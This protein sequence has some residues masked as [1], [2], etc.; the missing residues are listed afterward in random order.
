MEGNEDSKKR[1]A[2]GQLAAEITGALQ[3]HGRT[4]EENWLWRQLGDGHCSYGMCRHRHNRGLPLC[5]HSLTKLE[6]VCR[7]KSNLADRTPK[8]GGLRCF[9]HRP[10]MLE[11]NGEQ[12]HETAA[13]VWFLNA[14]DMSANVWDQ[15]NDLLRVWRDQDGDLR[16]LFCMPQF[17]ASLSIK[18]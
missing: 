13:V 7:I 15:W 3:K 2:A 14:G 9:Y 4:K 6:S 16:F 12:L 11:E 18:L 10:E 1:K 8:G 17:R 5:L